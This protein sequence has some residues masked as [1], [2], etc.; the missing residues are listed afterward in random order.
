M[1]FDRCHTR[2]DAAGLGYQ[3]DF[4]AMFKR[5]LFNGPAHKRFVVDQYSTKHTR[6]KQ[7]SK[8][9]QSASFSNKDTQKLKCH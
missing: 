9:S 8:D 6:F 4:R 7:S 3:S 1:P 5:H 2:T